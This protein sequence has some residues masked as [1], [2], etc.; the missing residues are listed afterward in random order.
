MALPLEWRQRP[1]LLLLLLVAASAVL[2]AAKPRIHIPDDLRDV[3][4]DDEDEDWK[5][6]ATHLLQRQIYA[7]LQTVV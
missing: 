6:T 4:D 1:L 3:P 7:S 5:V 2:V